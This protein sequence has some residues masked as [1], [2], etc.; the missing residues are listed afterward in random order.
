MHQYY[1]QNGTGVFKSGMRVVLSTVLWRI[2]SSSIQTMGLKV[3]KLK[4]V[5]AVKTVESVKRKRLDGEQVNKPKNSKKKS[6][7]KV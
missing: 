1:G 7:K 6:K 3:D 4:E 2:I 5:E